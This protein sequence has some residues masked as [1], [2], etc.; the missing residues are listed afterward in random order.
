MKTKLEIIKNTFSNF[1]NMYDVFNFMCGGSIIPIPDK[2]VP[3][4]EI[5]WDIKSRKVKILRSNY[6]T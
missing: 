4:F 5:V 3:S 1:V 6:K 2:Y